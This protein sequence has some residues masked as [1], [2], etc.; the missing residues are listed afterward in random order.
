MTAGGEFNCVLYV[1]HFDRGAQGVIEEALTSVLL[2]INRAH[3]IDGAGIHIT[4]EP[5][6]T[7]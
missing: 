4:G 5:K 3:G 1:D 7:P 6:A 2:F